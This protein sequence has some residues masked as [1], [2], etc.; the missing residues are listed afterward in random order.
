MTDERRGE[1]Y[2]NE[3]LPAARYRAWYVAGTWLVTG[4]TKARP[5]QPK[6]EFLR[7]G[8]GALE[9]AARY[10]RIWFDSVAGESAAARSPRAVNILPSGDR[11]LT[12]GVNWIVN[13]WITVQLNGIRERVEDSARSPVPNGAAFWSRTV[14]FQFVL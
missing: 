11:V 4:E 10:E 3:D 7:G 2:A 6:A 12:V 9:L 13:R 5:V 1:G 8:F 14:R